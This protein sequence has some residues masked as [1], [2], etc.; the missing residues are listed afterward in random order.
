MWCWPSACR[1]R[2]PPRPFGV[3][4]QLTCPLSAAGSETGLKLVFKGSSVKH[5]LHSGAKPACVCVLCTSG[6]DCT[7]EASR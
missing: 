5:L 1:G 2:H 7:L 6:H 3:S 4:L